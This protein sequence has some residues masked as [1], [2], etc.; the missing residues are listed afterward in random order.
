MFPLQCVYT[1][2]IEGTWTPFWSRVSNA[3]R[4]YTS[5][6]LLAC[7][8]TEKWSAVKLLS[9]WSLYLLTTQI[10]VC[11]N[12]FCFSV[13]GMRRDVNV[14]IYL[15]VK[16]A[17]EGISFQVLFFF[18]FFKVRRLLP[19]YFIFGRGNEALSFRQQGDIDRRFWWRRSRQIFWEDRI[20]AE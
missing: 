20:V 8:W 4:D 15:D 6:S 10:T 13:T 19:Y 16:K 11:G 12:L 3:W 1:V 17:L 2:P 5:T 14:L 9:L 18:F 7:Q